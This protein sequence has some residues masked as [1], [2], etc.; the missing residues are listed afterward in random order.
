MFY[1]WTVLNCDQLRRPPRRVASD[2]AACRWSVILKPPFY[3][4][5]DRSPSDSLQSLT[6]R[7]AAPLAHH[8]ARSSTT[9]PS[10]G[11]STAGVG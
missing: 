2:S 8:A 6:P 11:Q 4:G 1:L 9:P 5:D 10:L 3:V 7:R